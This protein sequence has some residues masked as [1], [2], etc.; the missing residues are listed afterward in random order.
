MIQKIQDD[1]VKIAEL[2]F[3]LKDQMESRKQYREK[4]LELEAKIFRFVRSIWSCQYAFIQEF[5]VLF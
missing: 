4:S 5:I 1:T 3:D 2:E